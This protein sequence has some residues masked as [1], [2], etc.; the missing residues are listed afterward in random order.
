[1]VSMP[2]IPTST[3]FV[4]ELSGDWWRRKRPTVT[5]LK[6]RNPTEH[7]IPVGPVSRQVCDFTGSKTEPPRK[8]TNQPCFVS[9]WFREMFSG[10]KKAFELSIGED[11]LVVCRVVRF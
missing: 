1:M 8:Q 7:S 10:L 4:T 6:L 11:V 5:R 3:D 9:E 2:E